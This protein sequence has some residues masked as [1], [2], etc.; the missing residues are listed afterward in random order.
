MLFFGAH[1]PVGPTAYLTLWGL[2]GLESIYKSRI[3]RVLALRR[4]IGFEGGRF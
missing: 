3:K 1:Y 2:P 4:M